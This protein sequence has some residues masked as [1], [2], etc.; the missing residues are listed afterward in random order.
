MR[1]YEALIYVENNNFFSR[2][3]GFYGMVGFTGTDRGASITIKSS[4]F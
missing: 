4:T 3:S 2:G 1:D